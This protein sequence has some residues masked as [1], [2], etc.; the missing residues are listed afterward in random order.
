MSI[1]LLDIVII[2]VGAIIGLTALVLLRLKVEPTEKKQYKKS[3][4]FL[5]MGGS[6]AIIGFVFGTL[7][8]GSG[9][10]DNALLALG[11]IFLCAGGVGI[12]SK[13]FRRW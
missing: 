4:S 11:I 1:E 9:I 3:G 6:W 8:R 10:F 12:I 13:Y 7:Y 2:A 5:F